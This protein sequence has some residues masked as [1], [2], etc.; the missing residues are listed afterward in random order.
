VLGWFLVLGTSTTTTSDGVSDCEGT[1]LGP[2]VVAGVVAILGVVGWRRATTGHVDSRLP[3]R[4]AW[5]G[6]A[7][8]GA[9]VAVHIARALLDPAGGVC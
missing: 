9:I 3:A 8:L 4:E 2:L 1:D 5:I 6:V 7:V